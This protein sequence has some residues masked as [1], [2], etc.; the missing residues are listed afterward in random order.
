M[1]DSLLNQVKHS[2]RNPVFGERPLHMYQSD[3]D[4]MPSVSDGT[5]SRDQWCPYYTAYEIMLVR[6]QLYSPIPHDGSPRILL[7]I[8]G[9]LVPS[10]PS[11]LYWVYSLHSS[12]LYVYKYVLQWILW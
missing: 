8:I 4:W 1:P 2:G 6:S 9:Y 5:L 3:N 12:M 10:A 11:S 7:C